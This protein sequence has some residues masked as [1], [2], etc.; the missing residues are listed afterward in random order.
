MQYV[1]D[2]RLRIEGSELEKFCLWLK[3]NN[4]QENLKLRALVNAFILLEIKNDEDLVEWNV[5]KQG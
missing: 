4:K 3:Q 1:D 2:N 5:A